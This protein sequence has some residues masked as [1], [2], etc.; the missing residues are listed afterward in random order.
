MINVL[1]QHHPDDNLLIEFASGSIDQGQ[2]IAVSAHL[3]YCSRCRNK[4][5]EFNA[6]GGALLSS[7]NATLNDKHPKEH[8]ALSFESLMTAIDQQDKEAVTI[9][10][11]AEH[12]P[13]NTSS[14]MLKTSPY[15]GLENLPTVIKKVVAEQK[16]QWKHITS[17]LK[18][19]NLITG[20]KKYGIYLQK[21]AAGGKVPEHNHQG[22][23]ITVVLKGSIS[24][25]D[26]IYHPGDFIVKLA[27]DIHRP[28]ASGNEDCVC[29]SIQEAPVLLT[30]VI[31]RLINPFLKIN[32]L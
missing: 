6:I 22:K 31:G 1:S 2:A 5:S 15:T 23:E 32:A 8:E 18:S 12:K 4:V 7:T 26:G 17:S 28:R 24:D 13:I 27:G 20:Q 14:S 19:A 29:L 21:I 16:I 9:A 3:H 30:S 11:K 10:E 25:E